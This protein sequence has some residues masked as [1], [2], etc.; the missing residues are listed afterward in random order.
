MLSIILPKTNDILHGGRKMNTKSLAELLQANISLYEKKIKM[1][2]WKLIISGV[3]AGMFIAIG[4]SSSSAAVYG[5]TNT[6]LAKTLAGAIF[7]VGLILVVLIGGEL[8]TGD[9]LMIM[10]VMDKRFGLMKLLRTL[11][12]VFIF[13]LVG[14]VIVALLVNSTC[15]LD[16]G[17]KALAASVIKT[18]YSKINIS[19][20]KALCSGIMCNILV[21][22]GVLLAGVCSSGIGKIFACFFPIWAFVIGG[23]EHCVANMYY[24]PSGIFAKMNPEYCNASIASGMTQS[25]LDELNFGSFFLNNLLPVTLGNIIGGMLFVALSLY[26]LKKNE[27]N[28]IN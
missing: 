22:L 6:G 16:Y 9:C 26:L 19:F 4:A 11:A 2:A 1:P 17:D 14:S 7:P 27:I 23:Y 5:I 21:C 18:A 13:N 20:F 12:L 8:F 10:G 28:K 15:Q 3:L 24:I 25:M